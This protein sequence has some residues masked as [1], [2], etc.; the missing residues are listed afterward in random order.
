MNLEEIKIKNSC[1][2]TVYY[3]HNSMLINV[4]G[5]VVTLNKDNIMKLKN[6]CDQLVSSSCLEHS[7]DGKSKP[8]TKCPKCLDLY[9]KNISEDF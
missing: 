5:K 1:D 8:K 7:Y 3:T 6:V 4:H 2:V 9:E